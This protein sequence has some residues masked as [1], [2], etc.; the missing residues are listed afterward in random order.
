VQ[1]MFSAV[2]CLLLTCVSLVIP[3]QAQPR[4]VALVVGID[5]Y[6]H[7]SKLEKAVNDAGAVAQVLR[8]DLAFSTV[9]TGEN[10][11]RRGMVRKLQELD[12]AIKPG[13]LVFF[14]FAGHGV[15][16]G[17][18]N[19]LLP[20][21]MP[22]PGNG[23]GGLVRRE[24]FPI[25]AIISDIQARGAT[26][27]MLVIDACRDNPFEQAGVRSL[28]AARGLTRIEAPQGV[29]VL[30]SAGYGQK[31]LDRLPGKDLSLTSVFT[32][33]LIPALR[34]PG[35]SHVQ[36]AKRVQQEVD[37]VA[38]AVPHQQQPAYYDQI[39]GDVFPLPLG[40]AGP[41]PVP[42]VPVSPD[43]KKAPTA[44]RPVV[45]LPTQVAT[46]AAAPSKPALK[47]AED[48]KKPSTPEANASPRP[49]QEA[50]K[51]KATDRAT[52]A[53]DQTVPTSLDEA[54]RLVRRSGSCSDARDV[55]VRGCRGR[56]QGMTCGFS[57]GDIHAKCLTNGIWS[58]GCYKAGLAQR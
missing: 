50:V 45:V 54:C 30:Y 41:T 11:D 23:E 49:K 56:S 19:I 40:N 21:D 53:V 52:S 28:G 42:P 18:D 39:I 37:A 3:A 14:F 9:I 57:C 35:L 22:K 13:D 10:L 33:H 48:Q 44:P 16:I 31:A 8:D 27:T 24:G 26:T 17:Q 34:T 4:R 12:T 29:F 38:R 2:L 51:P 58:G 55:C 47:S 20:A 15:A 25:G 6:A 32:R 1:S 46:P 7:L 5:A 43:A 36:I